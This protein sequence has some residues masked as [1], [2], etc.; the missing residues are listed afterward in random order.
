MGI[1]DAAARSASPPSDE[2]PAVISA[3]P[4]K[5][6]VHI[7]DLEG[8]PAADGHLTNSAASAPSLVVP[9]LKDGELIGASASTGRRCGPFTDK[10]IELVQ[11]FAAQ[12][13]IAIE[14]A[15]LLN[16]LRAI[17]G[18]ADGDLGGA[19]ASSPARPASLS[20]CSRRCWR[21]RR[22]SA[23]PISASCNF[24]RMAASALVAM[25]NPPPAYAESRRPPTGV[26]DPGA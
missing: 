23:R 22:A 9:M 11:N 26:S 19:R 1:A 20:R 10:Q 15:R 25:H 18:A 12:A 4:Q 17:A 21:T 16:E 24:A 5:S 6:F 13:V 3:R 8:E 2:R 14:N 7:A